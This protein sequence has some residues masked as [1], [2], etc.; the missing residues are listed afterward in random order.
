MS[1]F[2]FVDAEKAR[3][4]VSLLCKMV[5][6]SKSGYYAWKSRAPSKRSREDAVLTERIVEVHRRSREIYGY[7]Q[8]HAE[9]RALGVR[10]GR[11]RV[12]RLTRRAGVRGCMR[13]RKKRTTRRDLRATPAPD[14]VERNFA[15]TAPDRLWTADIST[16]SK[17]RKAS[18]TW[19]G[20]SILS[21]EVPL[22]Q[23]PWWVCVSRTGSLDTAELLVLFQLDSGGFARPRVWCSKN[24]RG[25]GEEVRRGSEQ[26]GG[27]AVA[28]TDPQG[29]LR[30]AQAPKGTDTARGRRGTHRPTD[31]PGPGHRGEDGRAGEEA[32]RGGGPPGGHLREAQAGQSAQAGRPSGGLPGGPGLLRSSRGSRQQ[33]LEHAATGREVGGTRGGR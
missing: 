32:L 29:R 23:L 30:R 9:L 2:G 4:P 1:R 12:A 8:V 14:L 28:R 16:M 5:G 7:L 26:R 18:S 24:G 22:L 11:R 25:T 20:S 6:I 27:R 17:R 10:C 21:G 15:A 19:L 33:A 3:F 13:G 31:S